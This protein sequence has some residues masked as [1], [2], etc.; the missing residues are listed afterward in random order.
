MGLGKIFGTILRVGL[1]LLGGG[2]KFGD[3]TVA[4]NPP[5]SIKDIVKAIAAAEV[6]FPD[7]G[8]GATKIKFVMPFAFQMLVQIF[9][10][11]TDENLA[12][13][14]VAAEKVASGMVDFWQL[15]KED[16]SSVN[17]VE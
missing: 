16:N 10:K 9:G 5:D 12:A 11:P 3:A 14:K 2:I 7:A 17:P 13:A 15:I 8:S 1:G 6:G 4:I